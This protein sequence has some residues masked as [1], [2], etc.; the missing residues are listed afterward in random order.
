MNQ[1]DDVRAGGARAACDRIAEGLLALKTTIDDI[2][3]ADRADG[4]V[5]LDFKIVGR[6]LQPGDKTRGED[7]TDAYGIGLL[8]HQVSGCPLIPL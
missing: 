6:Q 4:A 1:D 2:L 7:D 8:G 5:D 3:H